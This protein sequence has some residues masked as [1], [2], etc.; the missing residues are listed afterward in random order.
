MDPLENCAVCG[1]NPCT[2]ETPETPADEAVETAPEAEVAE[3]TEAA[4]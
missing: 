2:C 3:P 1:N 4:V